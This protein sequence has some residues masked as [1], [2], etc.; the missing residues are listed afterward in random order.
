ME[1]KQL[2]ARKIFNG[3]EKYH[4]QQITDSISFRVMGLFL[5]VIFSL[6]FVYEIFYLQSTRSYYYENM[7][8]ALTSQAR[9]NA[10][11]F[12]TYL[13]D[14]DINT[15]VLENKNQFYRSTPAQVQILN[16][17][18]VVL[19]DSIASKQLGEE[20]DS[21]DVTSA[22]ENKPSYI[23]YIPQY[24]DEEV[25][26]VSIPLKNQTNQVGILRLTTS[27]KEVNSVII[28]RFLFSLI[29][30]AFLLLLAAMLSFYIS[31]S[32]IKKIQNLTLVAN[33]L[34]DGQLDVRADEDNFGEIGDLARAMNIMSDNLQEKEKI[35][36]DFISSVSHELRTPMTSIKGWTITLQNDEIGDEIRKEGLKI[37]EKES[38]RLSGMVEDLLDFSRFASNR[39]RLKKTAFDLV[40]VSNNLLSQVRPRTREKEIDVVYSYSSPIVEIIADENRIKQ[41]LLNILDN[42]IKFTDN[43]GTIFLEIAEKDKSV[44]LAITDTGMGIAEDEIHLVT[45]KFWKGTSSQS[46]TGLGL[47]ICEEIV[48]AH[49]GTLTIKSQLNVGTKVII[50]LP[51]EAV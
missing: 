41:L 48:K 37:I 40:E 51:I 34:A 35:K 32:I 28:Q 38:E 5:M 2:R 27:L 23:V 19:Y 39:I 26:S 20:L 14:E 16:N 24:T 7:A 15:I 36:N 18:G 4:P 44:E 50:N 47:S 22:R 13:S 1:G 49:G 9:Y 12:L 29:F 30:S 33:K 46:H 3:H 25:M 6:I 45:E 42:A 43:G 11:L 17:A 21:S 10:D 31:R 8:G